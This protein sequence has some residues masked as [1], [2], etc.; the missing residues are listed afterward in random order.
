MPPICWQTLSPIS[1]PCLVGSPLKRW[2]KTALLEKRL[3]SL[4]RG[5]RTRTRMLLIRFLNLGDVEGNGHCFSTRETNGSHRSISLSYV[6]EPLL[7]QG[8]PKMACRADDAGENAGEVLRRQLVYAVLGVGCRSDQSVGLR[9]RIG[10]NMRHDFLFAERW[11]VG[12]QSYFQIF[13]W[14]SG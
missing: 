14:Q 5:Y 12:D 9:V 10:H 1:G 4:S 13:L 3:Q 11:P 2:G 6:E 8:G 7:I